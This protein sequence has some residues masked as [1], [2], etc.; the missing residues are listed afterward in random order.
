[1][2]PAR[3]G[4]RGDDGMLRLAEWQQ[5]DGF[6][7]GRESAYEAYESPKDEPESLRVSLRGVRWF[8]AVTDGP[9]HTLALG[10]AV[11]EVLDAHGHV[12]GDY[13]SWNTEVTVAG[14]EATLTGLVTSLPHAGGERAWDLWRAGWPMTAGAWAGLA[15]G[16]REAWLEVAAMV[17][18]RA[19]QDP[20]PVLDEQVDLDGRAVA[21][22]ASF[23]CAFGEAV[24][25]PGG[26]CGSDLPG[27][28]DCL[29]FAY[30]PGP[31]RTRLHWRD[32][33]VA[34]RSLARTVE[35][36]GRPTRYLDL[37]LGVLAEGGVDVVP[38]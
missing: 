13:A 34:E 22:L 24:R 32:F 16:E 5:M 17:A 8:D 1:M 38:A 4:L 21:D 37:V 25:G 30:R 14:A 10:D 7:V 20:Y 27:L 3:Y 2:E 28:A 35:V 31:A 15:V 9:A 36:D 23:L 18:F 33:A 6:F 11:L 19:D 29:G 12:L 26:Q